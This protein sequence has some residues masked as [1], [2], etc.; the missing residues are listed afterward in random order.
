MPPESNTL[1]PDRTPDRS[2][3]WALRGLFLSF[4]LSGFAIVGQ[5]TVVGKQVFDMTGRELDLGLLGLA[6]FLPVAFLVPFSGAA[7]DRFDRRHIYAIS[8]GR[9]PLFSRL[10]LLHLV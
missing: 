7:A 6:E 5:I 8:R 1:T 9:T 4:F 3:P 10:V 2:I